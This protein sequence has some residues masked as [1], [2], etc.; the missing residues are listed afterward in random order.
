MSGRPAWSSPWAGAVAAAGVA[1][2]LAAVVGVPSVLNYDTLHHLVWGR[3]LAGGELPSYDGD[4]R[5]TPHPLLLAV[6]ALLAP[7]DE[8]AVLAV[9]TVLGYACVGLVAWLVAV[10]AA[11]W[12]PVNAVALTAAVGAA[13]LV[14][15]REPVFSFGARAYVD[16]PYLAL[17]LAA[18]LREARGRPPAATLGLLVLAGLLRPEAW[19]FAFALVAWHRAWR[20]LP[21]AALAPALWALSDLAITG[22]PLF[23]LTGTREGAQELARRTGVDDLVTYAP[24][25]LGEVLGWPLV[26]ATP[27]AVVLAAR[28][29]AWLPLACVALALAAF[30]LL[31]AAGLSILT[32]YLLLAGALLCALIAAEASRRTWLAALLALVAVAVAAPRLGDTRAAL[33]TQA[34]IV[35]DLRALASTTERRCAGP[36]AVPNRR[37]VPH[38]ALRLDA[39]LDAIVATQVDGVPRGLYLV[40]AS[41]RVARQFVLDRRDRDRRIPAP[42]AGSRRLAAN[43]SWVAWCRA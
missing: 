8:P 17:V 35:D 2:L 27:V 38:L 21:L 26:V 36:L 9:V 22:D 43:A 23:S 1:A 6:G 29:R 25:R 4:L 24:F 32:R 42:R 34:R 13:V 12:R 3:E 39:D 40:P 41:A 30:A 37:A 20:L 14:V 19:L 11:E 16:L 31:A 7:L 15:T 10:L 28:R 33:T 18:V 5:P